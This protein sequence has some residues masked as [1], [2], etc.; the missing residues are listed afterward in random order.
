MLSWSCKAQINTTDLTCPCIVPKHGDVSETC[1]ME[2]GFID[3]KTYVSYICADN[4]TAHIIKEDYIYL[5]KDRFRFIR[6]HY[7]VDDPIQCIP[8]N[9]FEN[10][11]I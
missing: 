7:A 3:I 10:R 1:A 8:L 11:C 6:I 4:Y 5:K 9:I 2:Q